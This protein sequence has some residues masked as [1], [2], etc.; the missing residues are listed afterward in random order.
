MQVEIKLQDCFSS[1]TDTKT[2]EVDQETFE[3]MVK[4]VGTVFHQ[5]NNGIHWT[6]KVVSVNQLNN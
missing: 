5:F 4:G 3:K 1:A 2:K 6:W